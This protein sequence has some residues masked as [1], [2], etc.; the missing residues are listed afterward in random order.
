MKD[1][2]SCS[3]RDVPDLSGAWQAFNAE[4]TQ[5]SAIIFRR[6]LRGIMCDSQRTGSV[7]KGFGQTG[8]HALIYFKNN[9]DWLPLRSDFYEFRVLVSHSIDWG[10]CRAIYALFEQALS[11]VGQF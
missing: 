8:A 9:S 7:F 2:I 11:P 4:K 5:V 3:G 1:A 6:A 10:G